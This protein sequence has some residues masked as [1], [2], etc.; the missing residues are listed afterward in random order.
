M[1][2]EEGKVMTSFVT[3]GRECALYVLRNTKY[4]T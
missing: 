2:E 1:N 4:Y 3:V